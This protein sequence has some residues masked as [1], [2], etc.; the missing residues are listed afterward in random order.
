MSQPRISQAVTWEKHRIDIFLV[1]QEALVI[2]Q[3]QPD[4]PSIEADHKKHNLN[5]ELYRSFKRAAVKRGL[6]Y[7]IPTLDGKN[8]PSESDIE[9]HERET[10]VPDFYWQFADDVAGDVRRFVVECKRLGYPSSSTWKLN[11]NYVRNGIRRFISSPHEYGKDDDTAGMIGYVQSMELEDILQEVN[12]IAGSNREAVS[13]LQLSPDGWQE[14]GIST[15]VHD[16]E[17]PFPIS[18]FRIYH[19]WVD[20]RRDQGLPS[21]N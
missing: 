10:K 16:L 7:H 12:G 18:P 19:F 3:C 13:P 21:S 2:L 5:R 17:R 4:L 6:P 9:P 20:I 15:L 14:K 8:P 11:E 1:I